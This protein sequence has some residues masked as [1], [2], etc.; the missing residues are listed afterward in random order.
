M[1]TDKTPTVER[2]ICGISFQVYK[3][4]RSGQT[5]EDAWAEQLNKVFVRKVCTGFYRHIK[6]MHDNGASE[7]EIQQAFD[8]YVRSYEFR[9]TRSRS[10]SESKVET[11]ARALARKIIKDKL[12][13]SGQKLDRDDVARLADELYTKY[14]Q[15]F[16][17][18]A[19][20]KLEQD[21][22][23]RSELEELVSE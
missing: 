4:F 1:S 12:K 15:E 2:K 5:L 17:D 9:T 7:P 8:E 23:V 16:V 18:K 3:P 6:E 14:E 11:T 22:K 13:Q 21:A 10:C 19:T 20:K